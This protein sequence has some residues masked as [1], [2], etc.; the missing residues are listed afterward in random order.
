LQQHINNLTTLKIDPHLVPYHLNF[1]FSMIV[2]LIVKIM[3]TNFQ[4]H[5]TN[6]V[7]IMEQIV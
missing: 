2:I 4:Y 1:M 6:N 7:N 3:C 5:Q